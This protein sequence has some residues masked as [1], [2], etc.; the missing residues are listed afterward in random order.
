VHYHLALVV[1][2]VHVSNMVLLLM[3]INLF[4]Q[5]QSNRSRGLYRFKMVVCITNDH[6]G[7]PSKGSHRMHFRFIWTTLLD[8]K[9]TSEASLLIGTHLY[10][11]VGLKQQEMP[12]HS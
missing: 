10:R 12:V 6:T 3:V 1:W 8:Q 5:G 9:T 11:I 2:L 7:E 4:L